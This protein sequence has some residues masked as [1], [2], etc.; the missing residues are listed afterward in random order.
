MPYMVV[1]SDWGVERDCRRE[2]RDAG[3]VTYQPVTREQIVKHGRKIWAEKLLLGRYFFAKFTDGCAWRGLFNLRRVNGLFMTVPPMAGAGVD[4]PAPAPAPAL[5]SDAE[6]EAIRRCEDKSG[7]VL[8]SQSLLKDRFAKG[9]RVYA[10]AGVFIGIPGEFVG[11]GRSGCEIASLEL[12]GQPTRV[13]FRPG[14]LA[15]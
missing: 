5:V 12:F 13:E 11:V 7:F 2:V 1:V 8:T 10:T 9:Q 3:F 14:V 15:A 6:I 4:A